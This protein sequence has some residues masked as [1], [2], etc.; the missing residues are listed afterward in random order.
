MVRHA[1]GLLSCGEGSTS[2]TLTARG[3]NEEFSR[4]DS[5]R[6]RRHWIVFSASSAPLREFFENFRSNY[7]SPLVFG[8]WNYLPDD[9]QFV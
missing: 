7:E 3:G 8:H 4:A 1:E 9:Q 6:P 2:R 5:Q